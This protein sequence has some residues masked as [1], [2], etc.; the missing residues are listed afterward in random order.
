MK[1]FG[2]AR[3]RVPV[4]E[5][6]AV[7]TEEL[8]TRQNQMNT[9][10]FVIQQQQI[11]NLQEKHRLAGDNDS[12]S[13]SSDKDDYAHSSKGDV[14]DHCDSGYDSSSYGGYDSGDCGDGGGGGGD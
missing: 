14:A 1:R 10:L 12:R 5:R 3:K 9:M 2:F 13:R 7:T 11:L 6:V 8:L 4:Q